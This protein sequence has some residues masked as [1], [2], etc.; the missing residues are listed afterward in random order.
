MIT[1]DQLFV[2][3]ELIASIAEIRAAKTPLIDPLQRGAAAPD[4]RGRRRRGRT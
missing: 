1:K 2:Q 4:A 3:G